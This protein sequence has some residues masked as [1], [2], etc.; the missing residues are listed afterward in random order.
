MA[1]KD[2]DLYL[3]AR[4][5][6]ID[7]T[8]EHLTRE[9][10]RTGVTPPL[11]KE[12]DALQSA[13]ADYIGPYLIEAAKSAFAQ[14]EDG[15][16]P[17]RGGTLDIE[18]PEHSI[19]DEDGGRKNGFETAREVINHLNDSLGVDLLL[20]LTIEGQEKDENRARAARDNI[21][22]TVETI[23]WDFCQQLLAG[24]DWLERK[25]K[26]KKNFNNALDSGKSDPNKALSPKGDKKKPQGP[27]P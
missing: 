15:R 20:S 4:R 9:F 7:E 13:V 17:L 3:K 27:N 16:I 24:V 23:R 6:A 19:Y 21:L 2:K 26:L 5:E 25:S 8:L 10:K 12:H 14:I 1:D 18:I 22:D 11:G